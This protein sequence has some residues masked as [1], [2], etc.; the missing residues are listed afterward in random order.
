MR[1]KISDWGTDAWYMEA[2]EVEFEDGFYVLISTEPC[3]KTTN[4]D[5]KRHCKSSGPST[6]Y[7]IKA[8]KSRETERARALAFAERIVAL[9]KE[10]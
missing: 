7:A 2:V 5:Y 8:R 10:E 1:A 6:T 4:P 3:V 9:R